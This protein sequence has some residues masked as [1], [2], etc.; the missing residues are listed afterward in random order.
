MRNTAGQCIGRF[1]SLFVCA[2][3]FIALLFGGI[4]A[5]SAQQGRVTVTGDV[6]DETGAHISAAQV[7][8]VD[9]TGTEQQDVTNEQG[10]FVFRN[11]APGTY[12]VRVVAAG[13]ENYVGEPV[14]IA[15]GF[16]PMTVTLKVEGVTENVT[17]TADQ[18]IALDPNSNADATVLKEKDLEALPDDPDE[19]AEA[20]Q[21]MAGPGA[22]PGGGQFY[23]DGFSGGRLPPKSS[24]REIRINSNPFSAEYDRVGFG[25]IEIF[26]KPGSDKFRG[27]A[28]GSFTDESLNAR[29]PLAPVRASE[30]E[31]HY[32]VN[33]GGPLNKSASY[34]FDFDRREI[35]D[36][37]TINATTLN[38]AL[39]PVPFAST[40]AQPARRTEFS[41]RLDLQVG[42]KHTFVFRYEFE[43]DNR[44]N[45]GIGGYSLPSAAVSSRSRDQDFT[46]TDTFI[47]NPSLISET[48]IRLSRETSTREAV[49]SDGGPAIVVSDAFTSNSSAGTSEQTEQRFE[50]Q[51]YFNMVRGN[52]TIRT[53]VRLRGTKLTN[54]STS[55]YVG[56]YVFAGDVER[57]ASGQPIPGGDSISSIEQYRRVLLGVAGYRPSQF[58]VSGGDP[59]ASANQF[60][61]A[62][63]GQDEWRVRPNFTLSLGLRYE[64]QTNAGNDLNFAPRLGFAY[65]F[66]SA[67]GR[68]STVIRGG[69]GI[70]YDRVDDSLTL[71]EVRFDGIRQQQFIVARPDFFPLVPSENVLEGFRLPVSTR[72]LDALETPYQ[73]QGSIGVERQ[74]PL[75]ITGN[76]TYVWSRGVHQLRTR[77]INAPVPGTG[78]RPYGEA[79]GN[80]YSIEASGLSERHQ[81][82]IGFNRRAGRITLFGNYGLSFAN[83][84]TDGAGSQPANPY[85]LSDEYGRAS[86]DSRHFLFI[87]SNI[88]GPWGLQFSPFLFARSG[89]PYNITLGRDLNGDSVFTDRPGIA[90]ADTPDV[91]L[92]PIGYVDPIPGPNAVLIPRNAVTGPTFSRLNFSVSK[93]IGFGG[94]SAEAGNTGAGSVPGDSGGRGHGRGRFGGFGGGGSDSRYSLTVSVRA[95]NVLNHPSYFN[96]SGVLTSPTFGI[97]NAAASGRRV[98]L[99]MRFSF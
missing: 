56:T 69:F 68:P 45:G 5:A 88:Q 83:S 77:N 36:S 13:F 75:G 52:H 18:G 80:I 73:I 1:A 38:S 67:D 15:R 50:L 40:F 31:R 96:P 25:R 64:N 20:L 9:E 23:V 39:E 63:F 90:D 27:T 86:D 66:N 54:L 76:V 4:P 44:D 41:P 30:Q 82:R 22:G 8:L 61:V 2:S 85:D 59:F 26:T 47:I 89:R 14:A 53:G 48:R 74:L 60:D 43:Q 81:I 95:S 37:A 24:I 46:A 91:V 21:E 62:V 7:V 42:E 3:L 34:F 17:V 32:G 49:S 28:F 10:R 19:L 93:T 79:A 92:T 71:D 78:L 55:N 33:F 6:V 84:D 98:E 94:S 16:A 99:Q 87:G 35:D 70:F 57:D 65:S 51:Q 58:S 97:P 72:E 29:N 12:T 11:V